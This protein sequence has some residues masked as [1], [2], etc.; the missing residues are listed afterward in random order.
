[1]LGTFWHNHINPIIFNLIKAFKIP[2]KNLKPSAQKFSPHSYHK[3]LV[4]LPKNRLFIFTKESENFSF[5]P[6]EGKYQELELYNSMSG[7]NST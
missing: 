4:Y 7:F 1:M 3:I 6:S 2:T 5:F